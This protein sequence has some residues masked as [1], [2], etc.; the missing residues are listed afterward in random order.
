MR[1]ILVSITPLTIIAC[2]VH[3]VRGYD[4]SY[5]YHQMQ[6]GLFC[7][8]I[9]IIIIIHYYAH[10]RSHAPFTYHTQVCTDTLIVL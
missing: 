9:I 4:K 8:G 2:I 7:T 3:G 6:S 5:S 10:F 1:Y